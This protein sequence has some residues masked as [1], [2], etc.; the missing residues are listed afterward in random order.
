MANCIS[1]T[2]GLFWPSRNT[3]KFAALIFPTRH[4]ESSPQSLECKD[5]SICGLFLPIEDR[6][7]VFLA[8]RIGPAHTWAQNNGVQDNGHFSLPISFFPKKEATGFTWRDT[9][10]GF[11]VY[12]FLIFCFEI[13]KMQLWLFIYVVKRTLASRKLQSFRF[14]FCLRQQR[15]LFFSFWT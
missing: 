13:Q 10:K 6:I 12:K 3:R 4:W 5:F 15:C 11:K 7:S 2:L 1:A 9:K 14:T 8:G